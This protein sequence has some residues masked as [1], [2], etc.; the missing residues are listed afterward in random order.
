MKAIY[1]AL[2]GGGI[3]IFASCSKSSDQQ[4]DVSG[5][6]FSA[7]SYI[8]NG[9][10]LNSKNGS[11]GRA[12]KGTLKAG[13]T[14]Y[15]SSLYADATIN[16]GDTLVVQS[17]VKV[18]VVGPT[19]GAGA[20]CTQEHA[21]GF[22]INGTFLCLGTK[23]NPNYFTVADNSLKSDITK[24]PQDPKTDPAFKGYWGGFQGGSGAG[25]IIIKWTHIE[26]TGGLAPLS[27]P[28]PGTARYGIITQNPASNFVLEDSWLYGCANDVV[29]PA[30][31][32]YEIFRNTF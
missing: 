20:I 15:L 10:T 2:L 29:R 19:T 8:Q 16:S 25:D 30:G 24:D 28:K 27:G 3:L 18:L 11:N 1:S 22:I 4:V 31:G 6:Q 21:P 5:Q 17:G 9:D 7:G 26:Y 14:Y 32:K 13:Q 12:I 23:D